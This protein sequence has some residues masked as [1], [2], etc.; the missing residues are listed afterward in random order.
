MQRTQPP[1][2]QSSRPLR[3]NPQQILWQVRMEFIKLNL[4]DGSARPT[5]VVVQR[6]TAEYFG[7]DKAFPEFRLS[8][9]IRSDGSSYDT[10]TLRRDKSL[11]RGGDRLR[12]CRAASTSGNPA[13]KTHCFRM[14]GS[15]SRKHLAKLAAVAGDKFEWMEAEYGARIRRDDLLALASR[16][17]PPVY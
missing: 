11:H 13:G 2:V 14:V 12:I 6:Q 15:W 4:D 16:E 5:S 17:K 9:R 8:T 7:W 3:V 1:Q 10:P